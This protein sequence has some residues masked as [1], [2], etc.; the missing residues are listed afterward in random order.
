MA[1]LRDDLPYIWI[2]WLAKLLAGDSSCE[3]ATWFKARHEP[4]SWSKQPRQNSFQGWQLRHTAL[5]SAT[6][7]CLDEREYTVFVED[8][9]Y[10]R[11]RGREAGL[12]GKP[13]IIAVKG[14]E[15]LIIDCKGGIPRP[16]HTAQV[17]LYM[18]AIPN[19]LSQH[20]HVDFSGRVVYDDQEITMASTMIDDAF[21]GNAV[22]LI[23]RLGAEEPP[24]A[25]SEP[26][27]RF[28]DIG[29]EDCTDRVSA[30]AA[31]A[32]EGKTS[33]FWRSPAPCRHY[34]SWYRLARSVGELSGVPNV[35]RPMVILIMPSSPT[36]IESW[37][38]SELA[39]TSPL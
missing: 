18:Y 15:G 25:P 23:R 5:V 16:A 26:E 9:N 10:F 19:A 28:C 20:G 7:R 30:A 1:T 12:A 14:N 3:W 39:I 36:L 27:C 32:V 21:V 11:L 35:L 8:Q 17:M 37:T 22:N 2:T 31:A 34:S 24:R 38:S 6:A 29:L 4:G 33:D 13:D